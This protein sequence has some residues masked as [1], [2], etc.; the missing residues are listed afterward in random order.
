MLDSMLSLERTVHSYR[1]RPERIVCESLIIAIVLMTSW[2]CLDSKFCET[3]KFDNKSFL[4]KRE[5]KF[6]ERQLFANGLDRMPSLVGGA[7]R[8]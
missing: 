3:L 8:F 4:T 1:R 5:V 2:W 7:D 6:R